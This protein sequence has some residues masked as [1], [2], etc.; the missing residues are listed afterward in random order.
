MHLLTPLNVP[1]QFLLSR[2]PC[3]KSSAL[4]AAYMVR[5]DK[6]PLLLYSGNNSPKLG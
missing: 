3:F 2:I 5:A 1:F 6:S 4:Y